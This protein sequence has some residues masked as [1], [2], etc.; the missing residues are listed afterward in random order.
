MLLYPE[1]LIT[2]CRRTDLTTAAIPSMKSFSCKATDLSVFRILVSAC[3]VAMTTVL[4]LS[5]VRI[6][7]KAGITAFNMLCTEREKVLQVKVYGYF[8]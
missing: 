2:F 7:I 3:R 5:L 4:S 6:A 8:L 1:R